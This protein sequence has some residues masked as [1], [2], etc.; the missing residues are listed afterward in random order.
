M[1]DGYSLETLGIG[2]VELNVSV[3]NRKQQRCRLYETLYVPKQ[4]YNL[5]SVSRATSSG[6][7]FTFTESCC[8]LLDKKQ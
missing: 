7:S 4:S 8:Q 3:S 1:S 6:K 2:T 5:L